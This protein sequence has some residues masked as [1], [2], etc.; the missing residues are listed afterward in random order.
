MGKTDRA[1][2]TYRL[3]YLGVGHCNCLRLD[4]SL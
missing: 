1:R 3:L 2:A 4:P